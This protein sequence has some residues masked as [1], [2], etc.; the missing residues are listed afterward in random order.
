MGRTPV[1]RMKFFPILLLLPAALGQ[2][3]P[4]G[5]GCCLKKTVSGVA[6]DLNGVYIFSRTGGDSQDQ[7]CFEGCVYKKEGAPET[8]EYCFKSVTEGA[9]PSEPESTAPSEPE[10]TAPS[11]PESTAP[12]ESNSTAPTS[13]G[14]TMDPIAAI[15]AANEEIEKAN[16]EHATVSENVDTASNADSA[17]DN[18]QAALSPTS[19]TVGRRMRRQDESSTIGPVTSCE[20]FSKAYNSLLDELAKF[21]D[22]NVGLIKQLVEV[23][24]SALGTID[25]LCTPEAK[26]TL[27]DQSDSKVTAAKAKAAEYK[28][29]KEE[30]LVELVEI[31]KEALEQIEESNNILIA[32]SIG[33]VQPATPAFTIPTDAYYYGLNSSTS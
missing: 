24:N 7:D 21:S 32:S 12:S 15:D 2:T 19:T 27:K 11:E 30:R 5:G 8:N 4:A 22:D 29:E 28:E 16:A 17:V 9:A 31:V 20:E 33:T 13:A 25:T 3:S 23:L 26:Q 10:S 6:D 18:I 14:S 1:S